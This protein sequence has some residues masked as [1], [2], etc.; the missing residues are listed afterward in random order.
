MFSVQTTPVRV[1]NS[2]ELRHG[3]TLIELTIT[4]L[5]MGILAAVAAPHFAGALDHYRVE[6]AAARM[7]ADLNYV[8]R[9]AMNT[10]SNRNMKYSIHQNGNHSYAS[11]GAKGTPSPTHPTKALNVHFNVL[12]P[13][14]NLVSASFDGTTC[15]EFNLY[16]L[17]QTGDPLTSMTSGQIVIASGTEQRTIV[18]DPSTGKAD[19][20]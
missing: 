2:R 14:V 5:I 13:G 15:V 18:I 16:G 6:G 9:V 8:R 10:S 4:V 7:A 19:V 11:T 3:F 17:P 1:Q 12:L 20:Q